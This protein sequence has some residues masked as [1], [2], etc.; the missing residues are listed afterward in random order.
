MVQFGG[1]TIIAIGNDRIIVEG[2]VANVEITDF[3]LA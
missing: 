2:V 1:D 3:L